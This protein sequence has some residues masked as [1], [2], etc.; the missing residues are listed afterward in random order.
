MN[1]FILTAIIAPAFFGLTF[2]VHRFFFRESINSRDEYVITY[3]ISMLVVGVTFVVIALIHR[4]SLL[5]ITV[6]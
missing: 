6:I 3:L 1:E 2:I 4:I 5:I